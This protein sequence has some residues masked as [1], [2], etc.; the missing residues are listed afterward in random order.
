M[1]QKAEALIQGAKTDTDGAPIFT[2]SVDSPEDDK[3][4]KTLNSC[5]KIITVSNKCDV[6]IGGDTLNMVGNGNKLIECSIC[7]VKIH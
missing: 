7:K 3:V 5:S 2:S 1:N 4:Y 6:C